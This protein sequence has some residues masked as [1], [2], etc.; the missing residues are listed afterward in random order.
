MSEKRL[1]V[2]FTIANLILINGAIIAFLNLYYPLIGH[3]YHL[4]IPSVLDSAL[5]FRLN[6]LQIQWFTPSFGGGIPAF[7]NPNNGQFS[8]VVL[9][10]VFMPPWQAVILSTVIYICVGFIACSYFLRHTLKF[11]WTASILGAVFFSANGFMM[12]RVA[13]GHLGYFTF[14]LLVIFLIALIDEAFS[15]KTS[16]AIMGFLVGVLIHFAGYFILIVFAFSILIVLPV[17]YILDP[18]FI[19][20]KRFFTVLGSGAV[21]GLL[22]SISKL[23]SVYSFMR[24]FPRTVT[25]QFETPLL[26]GMIGLLLQLL[27][28][29]NLV[30]LLFAAGLKPDML[31]NFIFAASRAH[32]GFW[33]MD[34][35]ITPLVFII[36]LMGV[37]I[38]FHHPR[39]YLARLLRGRKKIA[40]LFLLFFVWLVVEFTLAKGVFYP[41]LRHLPILSSLHVNPRFAAAFIFPLAFVA[42]LIFN[43]WIVVQPV[44]RILPIFVVVNFLAV[45]PLGLYFT[46]KDDLVYRIYDIRLGQR[47][48]EQMQNSESFEVSAI[49]TTLSNTDALLTRTSNLNLYEPA[50]GYE[51]EYFH[52]QIQAGSIWDV[53]DGYYN[54]TDPSGF[55]YPELNNNEPFAT[56]PS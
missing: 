48:F 42:A 40:F 53:D 28:T 45:L 29:M 14:P 13:A 55:V 6:G 32:Y 7:P 41:V 2:I 34:M 37:D 26:L 54:M 31:P 25:D 4:G 1:M 22:I 30:P 43:K 27:G 18:A 5:H 12:E 19:N 50:F 21:V 23:A 46:Y 15:I 20:W 52:P 9:L 36:L 3:D 24:F 17:I 49:G 51:L 10:A 56:L 11:H 44:S 16:T 47:I 35:S 33:E 38:F 8:L 39:Q